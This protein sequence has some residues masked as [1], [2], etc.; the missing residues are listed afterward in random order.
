MPR[1]IY[2]T[3]LG[4]VVYREEADVVLSYSSLTQDRQSSAGLLRQAVSHV[5]KT[6][7]F[8]TPHRGSRA[9]VANFSVGRLF[10][11]LF[12]GGLLRTVHGLYRYIY[13]I[14]INICPVYYMSG[15]V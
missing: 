4:T 7:V 13:M 5:Y 11:L 6:H 1:G 9:S 10:D 12:L 3:L 14:K 15:L 8:P 2:G